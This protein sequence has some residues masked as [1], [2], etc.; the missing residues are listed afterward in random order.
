[1]ARRISKE[2]LQYMPEG[3]CIG[4]V[5]KRWLQIVTDHMV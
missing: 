3:R 4:H 5:A 2:I 1:M